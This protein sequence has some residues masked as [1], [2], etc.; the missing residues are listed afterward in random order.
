[1]SLKYLILAFSFV[2]FSCFT[3][4]QPVDIFEF[5]FKN[6]KKVLTTDKR[7]KLKHNNKG[8]IRINSV[9]SAYIDLDSRNYNYQLISPTPES[10]KPIFQFDSNKAFAD[11]KNESVSIFSPQSISKAFDYFDQLELIRAKS[12]ELY[13]VTKF[14]TNHNLADTKFSEIKVALGL[15]SISEIYHRIEVA[16]KYISLVKSILDLQLE[17]IELTDVKAVALIESHAQINNCTNKIERIDYRLKFRSIID[18]KSSK[19]YLTSDVF[20]SR[21]SGTI[22]T[23]SLIDSYMGD[24]LIKNQEIVIQ[25][26]RRFYFDFS[27]G[28]VGTNL[29][30][31]KYFKN[32]L[33]SLTY[34]VRSENRRKVDI[35]I[36]ALGHLTYAFSPVFRIG[37]CLGL[38]VSPFDAKARYL[39]GPSLM[40][41]HMKRLAISAGWSYA[42]IDDLSDS[43]IQGENNTYNISTNPDISTTTKLTTG[44]FI[45]V[46]YNLS[47]KRTEVK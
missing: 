14:N 15:S 2:L 33:D 13:H 9:N 36:G 11:F 6:E 28:F 47:L 8:A 45:S 24:T 22:V 46:T 23:L 16:K 29:V 25:S 39:Q 44:G 10:L 30:D 40:V 38:S 20:E 4:S 7:L 42:M 32:S 31:P 3:Y 5:D 17:N 21:N 41:G 1:M 18:S 27:T 43:M 19:D 37:W 12:D 34:N 35:S 26:Y